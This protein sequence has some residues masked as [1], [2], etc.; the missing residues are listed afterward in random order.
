MA[1]LAKKTPSEVDVEFSATSVSESIIK[2]DWLVRNPFYY[3]CSL[4]DLSYYDNVNKVWL[5]ASLNPATQALTSSYAMSG[6]RKTITLE[7]QAAKD[8]NISSSFTNV[9]IRTR[10]YER[11]NKDG[12][13][14]DY[15]SSSIASVDFRPTSSVKITRPYANENPLVIEFIASRA[16]TDCR[17]HY[18]VEV[19]TVDTFDS[20]NYASFNTQNAGNR[21]DFRY[22]KSGSY[23]SASFIA[24]PSTGVPASTTPSVKTWVQSLN[25]SGLANANWYIQVSQSVHNA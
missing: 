16:L 6:R 14:T 18:L 15:V 24:F 5:T 9:P 20:A 11:S 3:P 4:D 22:L 23:S 21:A 7:W 12:T 17:Y 19:D 25:H 10:F 8:L 13:L 2:V 1:Y